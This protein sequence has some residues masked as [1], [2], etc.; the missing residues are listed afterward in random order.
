MM[1]TCQ[2]PPEA[3]AAACEVRAQ[4][5]EKVV[6]PTNGKAG[7]FVDIQTAKAMLSLPLTEIRSTQYYFCKEADCPTVYY[8]AD[9]QTFTEAHLRER[10]YQKHPDDDAV[11]VCYCFQHTRGSIRDEWTKSGY[12][13]VVASITTGIQA[14]QCACDIRNPQGSCCLG[15]VIHLVKE[16]QVE[17]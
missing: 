1:E 9:G 6:C 5:F 2:C 17:Q 16:V 7:K 15:N 11:R 14:G 13:T 3:G 10:V 12:T 4:P 8:T